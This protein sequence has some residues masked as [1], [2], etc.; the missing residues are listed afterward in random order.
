MPFEPQS[1]DT[2]TLRMLSQFISPAGVTDTTQGGVGHGMI[3]LVARQLALVHHRIKRLYD[4]FG[5]GGSGTDLD[6]RCNLL[7]GF[8]GRIKESSA[9]GACMQFTRTDASTLITVPAGMRVANKDDPDAQVI[10]T[11]AFEM[12]IGELVYPPST[13]VAPVHVVSLARGARGNAEIG[14]IESIQIAT[15]DQI[16]SATNIRALTNGQERERD[17]ALRKRAF[18]FIASLCQTTPR[19]IEYI[20]RT[21]VAS[22]GTRALHAVVHADPL[23]PAYFEIVVDNGKGFESATRA[24]ATT[25]G[26][27][28]ENGQRELWIEGPAADTPTYQIGEVTYPPGNEVTWVTVHEEGRV[29]FDPDSPVLEPGVTWS[30]FDYEV[31]EEPFI[32]ELQEVVSGLLTVLNRSVGW[33]AKGV[34]GRVVRP[35]RDPLDFAGSLV[36][37]PGHTFAAVVARVKATIIAF[38]QQLAP[39]KPL[40]LLHLLA[41]IRTVAGVDDFKFAQPIDNRSP[42]S[43][44]ARFWTAEHMIQ[45]TPA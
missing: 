39:G 40:I 43:G 38:L 27:I 13:A 19:A 5:L 3:R 32:V 44:K 10:T 25:S 23:T 16:V 29:Y 11:E 42:T 2:F 45:I 34:R 28:P 17:D 4:A 36:I 18:D 41:V 7:P 22:N 6:D 15:H 20:A 26:T 1:A 35:T 21:F 24:G 14:Q 8:D 37:L 33:A 9:S 30:A 31:Y 12:Q